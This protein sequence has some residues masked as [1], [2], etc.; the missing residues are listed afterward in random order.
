M[1]TNPPR[2]RR[3]QSILMMI[4]KCVTVGLDKRGSPL[5]TAHFYTWTTIRI[6]NVS[7]ICSAQSLSIPE[8][9]T[10]SDKTF[11]NTIKAIRLLNNAFR[12]TLFKE[13]QVIREFPLCTVWNYC[14]ASG[15]A[16][17]LKTQFLRFR[18][19]KNMI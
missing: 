6:K 10:E 3:T 14:G 5:P 18:Y 1:R 8:P 2:A 12:L 17:F 19:H 11:L 16:N 4:S 7:S 9:N 15:I 13:G